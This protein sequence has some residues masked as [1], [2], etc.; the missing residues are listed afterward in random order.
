[1]PYYDTRMVYGAWRWSL[2]P[3]IHWTPHHHVYINHHNPFHWYSGIRISFNYFFSTFHWHNRHV[4][5]INPKRTHHYRARK[6]ITHGGY[7]KPWLHKP[8]HRRGVSYK[9]KIVREKYYGKSKKF[10][11]PKKHHNSI[12]PS[13]SL[14]KYHAAHTASS[15]HKLHQPTKGII[16]TSGASKRQVIQK[17]N[18][19][20]NKALLAKTPNVVTYKQQNRVVA[21]SHQQVKIKTNSMKR[22]VKTGG[23]VKKNVGYSKHSQSKHSQS[24]HSFNKHSH[25][26]H[27]HSKARK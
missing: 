25:S 18:K 9:N 1:M 19:N 16:S 17:V 3:P 22:P 27:G 21:K 24:K 6:L 5:V 12:N 26:K 10:N 23:Y 7:A 11:R 4:L 2:F 15:Q 8:V 14:N 13:V 20:N